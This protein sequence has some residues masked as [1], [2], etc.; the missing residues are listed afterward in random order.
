MPEFNYEARGLDGKRVSGTMT[1]VSE[2]DVISAL[3][4]KSLFPINVASTAPRRTASFGRGRVPDQALVNLFTSMAA[5]L[6][7]GVPLLRALK[8]VQ[9]QTSNSRLKSILENVIE[10][11]EDGESVGNAFARHPA[12]INEIT[13][14]LA[15]AGGEGGFLEDA[16]DRVAQFIE[17]RADLKSRTFGAMIYPAILATIGSIILIVLLVFFVPKF[18]ELFAELRQRGKLPWATDFLLGVSGFSQKYGLIVALVFA[19]LLA[20]AW[21]QLRTP[22]GRRTLDLLKL[23]LPLFGTI[24]RNLSIAR[25]CRVLGTLLKNGVPILKSLEISRDA[26]GNRV[27]SEAIAAAA[28][29]VTS[30]ESLAEPLR[31]SGHFP[32]TVTEMI[33]VAQESNTLDTVLI[34]LADGLEKQTM[35]RL[36]LLVRMLEP[37]MLVI[38]AGAV[39]V[40]VIALLLPVLRMGEAFT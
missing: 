29:N 8:V 14:N 16:F 23:R 28:E 12:V 35:R 32:A 15:R 4:G 24:L 27:L 34:S 26:T 18:G 7:G 9:E 25:F 5:L 40:I 36:D 37:A 33:A 31:K 11:V 10:R 38:L 6:R 3:T 22:A 30:G 39:M 17:H 20:F 1:A 13:I 19:I 2:R 21:V